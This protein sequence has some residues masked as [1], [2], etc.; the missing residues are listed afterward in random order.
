MN[1]YII[2]TAAFFSSLSQLGCSV[3]GESV[4]DRLYSIF[5]LCLNFTVKRQD[6]ANMELQNG[7]DQCQGLVKFQDPSTNTWWQACSSTAGESEAIVIC[8]QL[9]C[10]ISH[11]EVVESTQ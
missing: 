6:S 1:Q 3:T 2:F 4:K 8:R 11:A 5:L 7:T 9:G 10:N